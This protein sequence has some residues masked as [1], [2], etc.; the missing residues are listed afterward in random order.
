MSAP[1]F[2]DTERLDWVAQRVAAAYGVEPAGL[3]AEID[4]RIEAERANPPPPPWIDLTE[5]FPLDDTPVDV[6]ATDGSTGV[7]SYCSTAGDWYCHA[8]GQPRHGY[9]WS[10][11]K[12]RQAEVIQWRALS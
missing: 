5:E 11:L 3:R 2:S 7:A 9:L 8:P 10:E 6:L 12:G 1:S 4:A